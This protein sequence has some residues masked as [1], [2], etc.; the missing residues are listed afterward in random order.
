[1]T[2]AG[3]F[4]AAGGIVPNVTALAVS[5]STYTS[6]VGTT[7]VVVVSAPTANFTVANP[8]GTPVD[9]QKLWLR[10]KSGATPYTPTWGTQYLSSGV[11]TLPTSLPASKTATLAFMY[12]ATQGAYVLLAADTTGY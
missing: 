2:W 10:I 1:M 7:D 9:G 5:G 11:A 12:D 3:T 4:N 8:T 6:N